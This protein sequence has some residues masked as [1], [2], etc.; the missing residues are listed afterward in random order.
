MSAVELGIGSCDGLSD[1]SAVTCVASAT[2]ACDVGIEKRVGRVVE[3]V[4]VDGCA[5]AGVPAGGHREGDVLERLVVGG[6]DG[7][8]A[9]R[10]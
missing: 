1:D 2:F 8:A 7:Q 10:R 4:D 6:L 9:E 3:D 5:C